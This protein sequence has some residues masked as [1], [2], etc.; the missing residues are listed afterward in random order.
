MKN[1]KVQK[2]ICIDLDGTLITYKSGWM[3]SG[4]MGKVLPEAKEYL[5]RLKDD[6]WWIII[7]TVR[8]DRDR[9]KWWLAQGGIYKGI[10][11]DAINKRKNVYPNSYYGKIGC[12]IYA[13][14]RAITFKGSW[15]EIY[16][17]IKVF[18]P[19]GE[20]VKRKDGSGKVWFG[21]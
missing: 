21:F 12:D 13:D 18:R 20:K 19:W 9:I 8:A 14:D 5:R 10:H 6:K 4:R 2:I 1:K 11:Y 3:K 7:Y 17:E 16:E 15:K